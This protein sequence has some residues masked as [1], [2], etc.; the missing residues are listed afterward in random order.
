MTSGQR[1]HRAWYLAAAGLAALACSLPPATAGATPR[2]TATGS[3]FAG[4][5]NDV[6]CLAVADCWALGQDNAQHAVAEHW[7]GSAWTTV[8]VASPP[9]AVSTY[10]PS[11][12]CV[13]ETDCWAVGQY[14]KAARFLAY[15]EHWNGTAWSPVAVPVPSGTIVSL[16]ISVSCASGALPCVAASD[17]STNSRA[18][19]PTKLNTRQSD[20]R[21]RPSSASIRLTEWAKSA[22]E[23][24]SVPSRSKSR[25]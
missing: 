2:A 5:L 9:G 12:S 11:V 7:N 18:P 22:R 3:S 15:A 17:R 16:L 1:R 13:S 21:S 4:F 14:Q 20:N 8:G 23:S 25:H 24:T 10:L 6:D 19:S